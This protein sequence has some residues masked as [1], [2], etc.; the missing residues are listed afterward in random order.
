MLGIIKLI[1]LQ[2]VASPYDTKKFF[3]GKPQ[4]LIRRHKLTPSLTFIVPVLRDHLCHGNGFANR[5][6]GIDLYTHVAA[7]IREISGTDIIG[8]TE[9]QLNIAVSDDFSPQVIRISVLQLSKTLYSQHNPNVTGAAY[10]EAPCKIRAVLRTSDATDIVKLVQNQINR[11]RAP[12][13]F[14]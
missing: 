6:R 1:Q 3:V 7:A 4:D 5:H 8:T 2:D 12:P 10:A 11:N 14:A 13:A 9:H